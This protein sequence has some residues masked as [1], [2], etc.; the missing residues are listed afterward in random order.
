VI[1]EIRKDRKKPKGRVTRNLQESTRS[2][3]RTIPSSRTGR[4]ATLEMVIVVISIVRERA[5]SFFFL[6]I[7]FS[8]L[9]CFLDVSGEVEVLVNEL[10][11]NYNPSH[12]SELLAAMVRSANVKTRAVINHVLAGQ[13]IIVETWSALF[14][15]HLELYV[16][17][18]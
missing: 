10:S 3:T 13:T 16:S 2:C 17:G 4:N 9:L 11:F 14:E 6:L 1:R 12:R 5:L 18:H 8:G 15:I 7:F